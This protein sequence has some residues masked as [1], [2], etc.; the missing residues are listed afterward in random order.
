LFSLRRAGPADA[1][2]IRRLIRAAGINPFGLHWLRFIVAVNQ[3]GDI[4]GCGQVKRHR[5]SSH[6]LAS[7]AVIPEWQGRGVARA[8]IETL[9]AN[10]AGPIFLTCRASLENFYEKFAFYSISVEEMP[11]YFRRASLL[12]N[13]LHELGIVSQRL[14]V[15]KR[16]G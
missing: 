5:D 8:I 14:L 11:A 10:H 2:V 9:L 16:C 15:M 13:A 12:I 4:I 1:P 7:V 6:E 3:G